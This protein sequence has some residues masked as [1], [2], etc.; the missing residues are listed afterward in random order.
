M[1]LDVLED[2]LS[3]R[4]PKLIYTVPSFH[5]PTGVTMD[6]SARRRLIALAG[7]YRVPVVEDDIYRELR[8]DGA[9]LPSLKALDTQGL[10]IYINSFS[11]VG[12]PGLRV[13]WIAAPRVVI[14]YLNRAK[15]R[16]DLHASLLVQAAIYEF[17]RH[18]LMAKH[19]KRVRKAYAARRDAM[20]EAL[21]KH[22]PAEA[23]WNRPSG[24]MAIW[25]TLPESL[26]A[27]QLLHQA[28]EHGVT[29][30]PGNHFYSSSHRQNVMRL[31]FTIA[32]PAMIEEAIKRLGA[33][34]KGQLSKARKQRELHKPSGV[35]AIV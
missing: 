18:G 1:D 14:E 23:A 34:I 11:K 3:Q 32:G 15:Q 22:F 19:V 25:V 30:I 5:N 4:R 29:F 28:A 17:S 2:V 20:L 21:E 33:I 7:K 26:N 10:V 13:G 24:G 9:Q 12:F 27:N 31:G 6:I 8:Y 16:C 35:R